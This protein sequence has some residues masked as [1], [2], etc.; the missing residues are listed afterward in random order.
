MKM[1]TLPNSEALFFLA[2]MIMATAYSYPDYNLFRPSFCG[3][4]KSNRYMHSE[5]YFL[6]LTPNYRSIKS[7][8]KVKVPRKLKAGYFGTASMN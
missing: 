7:R 5:S 4:K 1:D 6:Y 2:Y 3:Y 8:D